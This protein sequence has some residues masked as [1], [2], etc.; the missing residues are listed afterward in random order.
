[1]IA[2]SQQALGFLLRS[3]TW[4][5][6]SW[7]ETFSTD[8]TPRHLHLQHN[9]KSFSAQGQTDQHNSDLLPD[10]GKWVIPCQLHPSLCVEGLCRVVEM[11]SRRI[12][13]WAECEARVLV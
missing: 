7:L 13:S 5:P 2:C 1:M 12:G 4:E 3:T 11:S 10:V 8:S 6:P 9:D